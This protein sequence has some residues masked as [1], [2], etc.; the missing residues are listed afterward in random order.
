[1]SPSLVR[2]NNKAKVL[3]N[4]S[5]GIKTIVVNLKKM[6]NLMEGRERD[7]EE[8]EMDDGS[9]IEE[10]EMDDEDIYNDEL[11]EDMYTCVMAIH[12]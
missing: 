5:A 3:E 2:T 4:L 8:K 12:A 1:M 11:Y 7:R 10:E 9:N 6:S